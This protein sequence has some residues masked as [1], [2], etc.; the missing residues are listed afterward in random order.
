MRVSTFSHL[1]TAVLA[2]LCIALPCSGA[3][4]KPYAK[5]KSAAVRVENQL[6]GTTNVKGPSGED[7]EYYFLKATIKAVTPATFTFRQGTCPLFDAEGKSNSDCW[8]SVTGGSAGLSFTTSAPVSMN[9]FVTSPSPGA[10]AAR[11]NASKVDGPTGELAFKLPANGFV[12][13]RFLWPVA[14]GFKPGKIRLDGIAEI[15]LK[16]L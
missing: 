3:S 16:K 6:Y 7:T 5:Q 13:L 10:P 8:I 12:D 15:N 2:T 4:L 9:T 14:K 11:L 1:T